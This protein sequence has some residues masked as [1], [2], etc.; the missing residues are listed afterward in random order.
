[1]CLDLISSHKGIETTSPWEIYQNSN[2]KD[3][4][5]LKSHR[6]EQTPQQRSPGIDQSMSK[7]ASRL[8]SKRTFGLIPWIPLKLQPAQKM[9]PNSVS[10]VELFAF[11]G[12]CWR[13]QK[14]QW[15]IRAA[16]CNMVAQGWFSWEVTYWIFLM[17]CLPTQWHESQSP[18]GPV[19]Q[20]VMTLPHN[21][22]P[23]FN[24]TC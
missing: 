16:E 20:L 24:Q 17:L 2:N 21:Q 12:T 9:L 5:S 8:C 4:F 23:W 10:T 11:E 15:E 19:V 1:M 18:G 14:D 22:R 13:K 6:S 7:G 3:K